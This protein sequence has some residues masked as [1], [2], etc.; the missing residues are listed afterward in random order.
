MSECKR[1]EDWE[2]EDESEVPKYA[3]MLLDWNGGG[4]VVA[5]H[6]ADLPCEA[7]MAVKRSAWVVCGIETFIEDRLS[8][9]VADAWLIPW[10]GEGWF[11]FPQFYLSTGCLLWLRLPLSLS[12][13]IALAES[14][15]W[16]TI[17]AVPLSH[18]SPMPS[19]G[20]PPRA[21]VRAWKQICDLLP[22]KCEGDEKDEM[23]RL[24]RTV[25]ALHG[26][27]EDIVLSR[28]LREQMPGEACDV[29]EAPQDLYMFTVMSLVL[30]S[31]LRRCRV[32]SFSAV[33][34]RLEEGISV[35]FSASMPSAAR[36]E[37][38]AGIDFCRAMSE[39]NQQIFSCLGQGRLWRAVICTV[40]K[41]YAL[42]GVK[43]ETDE[44][45]E[46]IR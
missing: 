31:A 28:S 9:P 16:G 6:G 42:L 36:M 13:G 10:N 27:R 19:A 17:E 33:F 40:R 25:A 21:A 35:V 7:G 26:M 18:V 1:V 23:V 14:G 43:T 45:I 32:R 44:M 37:T 20:R 29:E 5:C 15:E 24:L 2:T 11:V 8:A 12:Q 3:W 30:L 39:C 22:R 4:L 46:Q 41:D 38:A 34:E